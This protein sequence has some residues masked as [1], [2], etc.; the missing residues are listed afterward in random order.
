MLLDPPYD[1]IRPDL[2]QTLI[3][4]HVKKDGLVVLSYPGHE[5]APEYDNMK[6]LADKKYGDAQLVFYRKI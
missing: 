5:K 4:R 2:L 6:V 1:Q 3:K